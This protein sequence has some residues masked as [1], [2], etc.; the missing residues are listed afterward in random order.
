[1]KAS[2]V[3][4]GV[5]IMHNNQPHRVMEFHHHTPGNLRAMVQVKMRNLLSGNQTEVR[6]SSNDELVEADAR[7]TPATFL[8]SDTNGFHFMMSD[9]YEEITVNADLIGDDKYY[10][11]DQMPVEITLF[12]SEPIG[13]ALPGT[14]TLTIVE[15]QPEVRGGTASN[16]PKPA[17]TD[18]GLTLNVP[19]FVKQGERVVVSTE[20][21]RYLE[22]AG[23]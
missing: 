19:A 18:T 23:N 3:R 6:Y 16:S 7:T 5:L 13:V 9:S 2:N 11:Q 8:Y 22:R 4:K 10:L 20:D 15:T 12:E 21:G 1:M 17:T 14:V